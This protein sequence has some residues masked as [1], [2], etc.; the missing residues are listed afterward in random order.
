MSRPF[1]IHCIA[2]LLSL[3]LGVPHAV[4]AAEPPAAQTL[5]P[6]QNGSPLYI[7]QPGDILEVSVWKEPTVSRDGVLVRPDGRMSIPLAQDVQAAG[8]NPTQL[9]EKLEEMFK[10]FI[11]VPVVTVTVK[12]IQSYVVYV[13]GSVAKNGPIMSQSPLTVMQVLSIAGGTTQFAKRNE[14]VILHGSGEDTK[15]YSFNYDEFVSGKN[16]N[17]NDLLR[18]G[19]TIIVP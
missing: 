1:H 12:A 14:I 4:Y 16:F 7:I 15:R 13:F 10:E 5:L 3:V 19:D 17:Q 2:A 18:S 8:L 11:N 6:K 9:K